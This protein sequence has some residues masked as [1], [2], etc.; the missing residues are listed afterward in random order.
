M[1]TTKFADV[2][3]VRLP[4]AGQ[5]PERRDLPAGLLDLAGTGQAASHGVV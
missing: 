2:A 1:A 5:H 3:V 4:V